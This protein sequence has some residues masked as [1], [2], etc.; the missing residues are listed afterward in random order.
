L[1]GWSALATTDIV[2]QS[3]TGIGEIEN[4]G[5]LL[6]APVPNPASEVTQVNFTLPRAA[7]LTLTVVDML[8]RPVAQRTRNYTAGAQVENINVSNL[9]NGTYFILLD[10]EGSRLLQKLVVSK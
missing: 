3:T 5:F 2:V 6:D 1:A 10:A 8:G 7:Q 9:P 4:Q